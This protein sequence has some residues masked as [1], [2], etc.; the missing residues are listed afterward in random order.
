ML[1]FV[2]KDMSFS[3]ERKAVLFEMLSGPE[4]AKEDFIYLFE[5]F[6]ENSFSVIEPKLERTLPKVATDLKKEIEASGIK[7]LKT[8]IKNID[9]TS[10]EELE[11]TVICPS[12]F[13]EFLV[14]NAA[15]PFVKEDMYTVG[16]RFREV[17]TIPKNQLETSADTFDALAH[18]KRLALIRASI[19]GPIFRT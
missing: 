5:W 1:L 15:I 10:Y 2:S 11:R 18:E 6:Y 14:S 19:D 12:Y 16:F 4:K 13:S 7:F 3:P 8:L 17:M 9:Y